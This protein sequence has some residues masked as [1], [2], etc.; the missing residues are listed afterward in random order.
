M[1]CI[2]ALDAGGTKCDALLIDVAGHVIGYGSDSTPG[3]GGRDARAVQ[4][5]AARAL[6]R[7]EFGIL[8]VIALGQYLPLNVFSTTKADYYNIIV[9]TESTSAFSHAGISRGAVLLAGTGAFAHAYTRDDRHRHLDGT[10]PMLG[11]FGG[12]YHV[13][14]MA[15]NAIVRSDWHPRH[16]TSLRDRIL[17]H[18]NVPCPEA[19]FG[20]QLFSR[21]RSVVASVARIVAEEADSGDAVAAE[22]LRRAAQTLAETFRDLVTGLGIADEEYTAIGTGSLIRRSDIYW[23][24]LWA[25]ATRIA[26]RFVPCRLKE[27]PVISLAIH[28]LRQVQ[29]DYA[30]TAIA[31]LM[32]EYK[33]PVSPALPPRNGNGL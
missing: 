24:E 3:I 14:T 1:D 21:D 18:F 29:G 5:A 20:L 16:R 11:D 12:G 10:G 4:Y 23:N 31:A 17:K 28:A 13:G 7:H 33:E 19:L 6:T 27:P 8:H 26:P 15:L 9:C 32:S 30:A 2:L 22:I 25:C